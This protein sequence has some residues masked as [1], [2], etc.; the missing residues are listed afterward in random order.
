MA[1]EYSINLGAYTGDNIALAP[2]GVDRDEL[3]LD[4]LTGKMY[5]FNGTAWVEV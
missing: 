1:W 5:V 4:Y 2:T 3:A